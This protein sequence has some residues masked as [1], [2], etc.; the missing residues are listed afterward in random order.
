VQTPFASDWT[1]VPVG[2]AP[3]EA[4]G[5]K[6]FHKT[7]KAFAALV[8]KAGGVIVAVGTVAWPKRPV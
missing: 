7:G 2:Y 1:A 5:Y 6:Q 8:E 3:V 4:T